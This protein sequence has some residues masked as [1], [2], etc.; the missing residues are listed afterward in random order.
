MDRERAFELFTSSAAQGFAKAEY[1]LANHYRGRTGRALDLDMASSY[2][3]RSARHGYVP[4][5]V[6][7]GFVYFN[8]SGRTPKDLVR[9]FHWFKRAAD[10][11]AVI[12]Q[13][14]VADFYRQGL[15]GVERNP[16]E[17]FRWYRL[18]ATRADRCA[19]KS[20]YE[21]YASYA[22]GSGVRKD[23]PTAMDWLKRA[24]EAGNPQAQRALSR[25]YENGAGVPRDPVLARM[26]LRKSREGVAPHDDHEHEDESKPAHA[27]RPA[28]AH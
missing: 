21:L 17:A 2:L 26:W 4:A 13:C 5:Q 15:G 25:A 16:R 27:P 12:A 20:Q 19:A 6:D 9:S 22:S 23:L 1:E 3:E 11:G 28:H 18:S 8:G 10:G 24:A 14:M 7:L